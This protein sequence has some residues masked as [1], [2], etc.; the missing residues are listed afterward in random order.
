[1]WINIEYMLMLVVR[2]YSQQKVESFIKKNRN[3]KKAKI[4]MDNIFNTGN[5]IAKIVYEKLTHNIYRN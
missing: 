3:L 4:L 5:I 1:M 2:I